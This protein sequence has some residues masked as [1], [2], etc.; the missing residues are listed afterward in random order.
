[1][2]IP[3]EKIGHGAPL[4]KIGGK[5]AGLGR[6]LAAGARIP[7]FFVL[8]PEWN[9]KTEQQ[10]LK[11]ALSTLG[12]GPWAVRSS[13]I[14]EDGTNTS[15]AGQFQT[16]LGATSLT[17][18]L[19]AIQTC[20]DSAQSKTVAAYCKFHGIQPGPVAVIVQK[21]IEGECSGVA[22]SRD[23]QDPEFVLIS[24]AWGLGQGIVQGQINSDSYR[25][26]P[27]GGIL[28]EIGLKPS[29]LR[30]VDGQIR[31]V[32]VPDE[33]QHIAV[34]N[35]SQ[36]L[37]L[38]RWSRS[39]EAQLDC[40]QD[41]EWTVDQGEL[42]LLQ[43]RPITV[44]APWGHRVL[45]DNS[46]IE[47][48][49]SGTTTPL[50]FS[51]ARNTYTIF[52]QLF[53]RVMG[54]RKSVISENRESF[55]GMTGLIKGRIYY[56]INAWYRVVAMLPGYRFNRHAMEE[57]MGVS[58][59]AAD[60]D[61]QDPRWQE[62]ILVTPKIIGLAASVLWRGVRINADCERFEKEF[63]AV[64]RPW[65]K[66]NLQAMSP[67]ELRF[68]YADLE[69]KLLWNWTT[70][71]INDWFRLI[72]HSRLTQR[73]E[74]W[75][76]EPEESD[77]ANALLAGE[78]NLESIAQTREL[79]REVLRIRQDS[80]LLALFSADKSDKEI[81]ATAIQNTKFAVF[82][83]NYAEAWGDRCADDLKLET[84]PFKAQPDLLIRTLRNYLE[85]PPMDPNRFGESENAS[86]KAAETLARQ[87]LGFFKHYR[88][89]KGVRKTRAC[90]AKR[91]SL[92]FLRTKVFALVRDIFRSMGEQMATTGTLKD[93]YDI[94]FLNLEEVWAWVDKSTVSVELQALVDTRK[95]EFEA[96][97]Q[98]P[99]PPERFYTYG[100]VER[101]NQLLGDHPV[102]NMDEQG[103]IRGTPCFPGL[104]EETVVI[105]HEPGDRFS[106]KGQILVAPRTDPHWVPLFSSISGLLIEGGNLLSH[107][108]VIARELG[109][110]TIVGLR[111]ITDTLE[112]GEQIRMDGAMGTVERLVDISEE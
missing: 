98:T 72:H 35:E 6:L 38:G 33:A 46:D 59:A 48:S 16:V 50:T 27:Q 92:D 100:P 14:A 3:Q 64:Y 23:P 61:T 103:F 55:Q 82:F 56:N 112:D 66:S 97:K 57:M 19:A 65:R 2:V 30:L 106:L 63:E 93:P 8:A 91:E 78:A 40:P 18:V 69:Q 42:Y 20:R 41:M 109:I 54:A 49:F 84:T 9:A 75:V 15:F 110:P 105:R 83:E 62:R 36:I 81:Y 26:D 108:A 5:A 21:M 32:P 44:P 53:C 70:P 76:G 87:R 99:P 94:F 31:E 71:L 12:E 95:A 24:A 68:A 77:L 28:G 86:R 96:Y 85:G 13:A 45:W 73:C 4:E 39:I 80:Q 102:A 10:S 88:F 43:T 104:V 7:P 51:F 60:E 90:A 111:G 67:E 52:H 17:D 58:E 47:D 29:C 22:F 74:E 25:V 34:L 79:L 101:H 1:M 37:E 11:E 107:F 89:M